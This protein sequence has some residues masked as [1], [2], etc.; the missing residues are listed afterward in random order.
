[1]RS[2]APPLLP[3]LLDAVPSVDYVVPTIDRQTGRPLDEISVAD[4]ERWRVRR[5]SLNEV[6]AVIVD[7]DELV[8]VRAD[9]VRLE[10]G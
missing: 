9:Q 8:D 4:D 2:A 10:I 6:D 3:L 1:M 7:A 5:N